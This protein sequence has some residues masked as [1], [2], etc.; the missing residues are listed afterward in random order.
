MCVSTDVDADQDGYPANAVRGTQCNGDDC[1]DSQAGVFPGAP[2]VCNGRDDN[3]DGKVDEDCMLSP[4]NCD[5]AVDVVLKNGSGMVEG[6]FAVA[7][8]SDFDVGCGN[9]GA[10]DAV[11]RVGAA[12]LAGRRR[13]REHREERGAHAG[14]RGRL[15]PIRHPGRCARSL[16]SEARPVLLSIVFR[17]TSC[18]SWWMPRTRARRAAINSRC[19]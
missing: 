8:A 3:C 15:Q 13:D 7:L 14:C 18:S 12:W 1:D 9:N 16:S 2:E 5:M 17:A 19:R 4:D 10:P 6:G 11:Y